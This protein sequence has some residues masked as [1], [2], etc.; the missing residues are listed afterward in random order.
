M[1]NSGFRIAKYDTDLRILNDHVVEL[2]RATRDAM[3]NAC[4]AL[5]ERNIEKAESVVHNDDVIDH[6]E[7]MIHKTASDLIMRYQPISSDLRQILASMR[8]ASDLERIGDTAEGIAR[9]VLGLG[10]KPLLAVRRIGALANLVMER[11][12]RL[13]NAYE[14][15]STINADDIR[16]HDDDVDAA[17]AAASSDILSMMENDPTFVRTGAQLL[18]VAKSF[19]RVGDRLTNVAEQIL[20]EIDGQTEFEHRPKLGTGG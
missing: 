11:F 12:N 20:Y 17:Y 13:V 5:S 15:R 19:E 16:A 2:L 10:D 3:A 18:S 14:T 9:R 1:A 6:L 7:L 8:V 4:E